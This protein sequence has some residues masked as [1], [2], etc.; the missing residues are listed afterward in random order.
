MCGLVGYEVE[1][2]ELEELIGGMGATQVRMA[3]LI[4][5]SE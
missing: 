5:D 2:I 4:S 3:L 1:G